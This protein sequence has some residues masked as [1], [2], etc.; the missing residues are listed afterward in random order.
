MHPCIQIHVD[1]YFY[2][3]KLSKKSLTTSVPYTATFGCQKFEQTA[4][5]KSAEEGSKYKVMHLHR[6]RGK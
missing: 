5:N 3:C 2:T 4:Q 1:H 6:I